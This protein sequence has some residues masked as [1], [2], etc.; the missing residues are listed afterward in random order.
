MK[1]LVLILMT[2]SSLSSF[3]Q[4]EVLHKI[5]PDGTMYY[6]M[7]PVNFYFTKEKALKGGIV[8]DKENYYLALQPTPFPGKSKGNKFKEDLVVKL[9]NNGVYSLQ[10]FD[11][12]YMNKD[13]TLQLLYCI[14]KKDLNDFLN[15]EAVEA[16]IDMMGTEGIRTYLFKLHKKALQEQL[17]CFLKKEAEKK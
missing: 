3:P 5:F 16:K 7:Q 8:T 13:S 2:L 4:C 17:A 15:F 11:T 9:A 10:H 12:K 1:Y 6:S 14:N